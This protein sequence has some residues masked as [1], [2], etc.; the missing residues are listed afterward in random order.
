MLDSNTDFYG[1]E[2][3]WS[4][5]SDESDLS[6]KRAPRVKGR[7]L[8]RTQKADWIDTGFRSGGKTFPAQPKYYLY[9]MLDIKKSCLHQALPK[10][11][12]CRNGRN[13]RF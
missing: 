9:E 11:P 1:G 4:D 2:G 5:L 13:K 6:D 3:E 12:H 8:R 7:D 10:T